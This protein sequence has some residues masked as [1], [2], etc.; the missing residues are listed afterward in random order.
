VKRTPLNAEDINLDA[1]FGE[2]DLAETPLLLAQLQRANSRL[3]DLREAL[4]GHGGGP[5]AFDGVY[6]DTFPSG[7]AC[8]TAYVE[9]SDLCFWLEL[10]PLG[11]EGWEVAGS[12]LLAAS[13]GSET[14]AELPERRSAS[15]LAACAAFAAAA[16]E[17]SDLALSR[18]PLPSAWPAH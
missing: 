12:V 7:Q 8:I 11:A 10:S 13:D 5:W 18:P 9:D 3:L 6:V 4:L 1:V 17:L 14:V 15:P 16:S 2:L